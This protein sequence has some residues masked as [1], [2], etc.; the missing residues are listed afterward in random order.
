[1]PP[2]KDEYDDDDLLNGPDDDGEEFSMG[3]EPGEDPGQGEDIDFGA[4]EE[5]EPE[6]DETSAEEDPDDIVEVDAETDEDAGEGLTKWE[7]EN[8]SKAMQDRVLRERRLRRQAEERAEELDRRTREL[9]L[10]AYNSDKAGLDILSSSI[11]RDIKEKTAELKIAKEE[12]NTDNEISL[13]GELEELRAKKR[14]VESTKETLRK[15][16]EKPVIN[17][18]AKRWLDRNR[19]FSNEAFRAEQG[20]AQAIDSALA[21]EG[22]LKPDTPEYFVELDKRIHERIPVL[23]SKIKKVFGGNAPTNK[24]AP[25]GMR[26]SVAQK[27]VGNKVVLTKEDLRNAQDFGIDIKNKTQLAAYARAKRDRELAERNERAR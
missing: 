24:A 14:K 16:E 13:T 22:K 3:D 10:R 15:P 26:R 7:K 1:M 9:E 27:P 20:Y 5:V 23:R 8:Y 18:M 11:D 25:V 4:P 6:A 19:W 12:G 17:T 2:K 21:A